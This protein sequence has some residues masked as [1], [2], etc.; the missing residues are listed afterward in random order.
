[1]FRDFGFQIINFRLSTWPFTDNFIRNRRSNPPEMTFFVPLNEI[2]SLENIRN[3]IYP[4]SL[5]LKVIYGLVKVQTL[6][7]SIQEQANEL[8]CQLYKT[9]FPLLV[10][11]I[12]RTLKAWV[13]VLSHWPSYTLACSSAQSLPVMSSSRDLFVSKAWTIQVAPRLSWRLESLVFGLALYPIFSILIIM[14]RAIRVFHNILS[15]VALLPIFDI[16]R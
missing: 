9:I 8:L 2:N 7:R 10:I 3:V 13:F 1:M 15:R 6:F 4:S 12:V 16:K 5:D 14:F 11:I